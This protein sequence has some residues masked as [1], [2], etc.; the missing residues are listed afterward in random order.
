MVGGA[1]PTGLG[2]LRHRGGV[3]SPSMSPRWVR[4]RGFDAPNQP[5]FSHSTGQGSGETIESTGGKP[6]KDRQLTSLDRFPILRKTRSWAFKTQGGRKTNDH[7]RFV[8]EI[9]M[10]GKRTIRER[11]TLPRL[12]RVPT[13]LR[14]LDAD[15][16]THGFLDPQRSRNPPL[17]TVL[18]RW[19]G[20][21]DQPARLHIPQFQRHP[22]LPRE[23]T[24]Q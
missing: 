5:H 8:G 7:K 19:P 16:W 6:A 9:P 24:K 17:S 15:L 22:A 23:K 10:A 18:L 20:N 4:F 14:T 13:I 21:H 3:S 2:E 12:F 11:L 1:H